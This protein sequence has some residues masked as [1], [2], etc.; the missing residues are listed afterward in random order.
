MVYGLGGLL[1]QGQVIGLSRWINT[2]FGWIPIFKVNGADPSSPL[3][4]TTV[5]SAPIFI[6]GVVVAMMVMPIQCV[7]MREVFSQVPIGEREGAALG[8]TR[9]G[10]IR[11]LHCR[12]A[13]A[14]SS[15]ARYEHW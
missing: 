13:E 1:L 6:A 9:W 8:S 3:S 14:A 4:T 11:S 5:Y 7:V 12:S 2:W 10:M 15:A